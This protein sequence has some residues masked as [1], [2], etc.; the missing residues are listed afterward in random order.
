[1]AIIRVKDTGS[2]EIR[3]DPIQTQDAALATANNER[4]IKAMSTLRSYSDSLLDARQEAEDNEYV[5]TQSTEAELLYTQRYAELQTEARVNPEGASKRYMDFVNQDVEKRLST[6]RSPSVRRALDSQLSDKMARYGTR[7]I[8][9]ENNRKVELLQERTEAQIATREELAARAASLSDAVRIY[10]EGVG[11]INNMA[12]ILPKEALVVKRDQLKGKV[13]GTA[14]EAVIADNPDRALAQLQSGE[15]DQYLNPIQKQRA[16]AVAGSRITTINTINSRK[17]MDAAKV[18]LV[19]QEQFG[20]DGLRLVP[21]I[22]RVAGTDAANQ[23]IAELMIAKETNVLTN[24]AKSMSEE[25][26]A[27]TQAQMINEL[28][29]PGVENFEEKRRQLEMFNRVSSAVLEKRKE[30]PARAAREAIGVSGA[31]VEDVIAMQR[32]WGMGE[33][34]IGVLDDPKAIVKQITEADSIEAKITLLD[35]LRENTGDY[36]RYAVQD[37]V[38][39]GLDKEYVAFAYFDPIADAGNRLTAGRV[40]GS[41]LA[42]LRGKAGD[43]LTAE[44][45][46]AAVVDK[47]APF[48]AT[49]RHNNTAEAYRPLEIL[50]EK[51]A[52]DYVATGKSVK[53]AAETAAKVITDSFTFVDQNKAFFFAEDNL[54]P[55]RIPKKTLQGREINPD[56]ID[57]VRRRY[58]DLLKNSEIIMNNSDVPLDDVFRSVAVEQ[59][60]WVT[61]P[62]DSGIDFYYEGFPLKQKVG[63]KEDFITINFDEAL[64]IGVVNTEAMRGK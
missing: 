13:F 55:I 64:T 19:Q 60:Y 24:Q 57:A 34:Q 29:Q 17:V 56:T 25:N 12:E 33:G 18:A 21:E 61:R 7:A 5:A 50:I 35:G 2:R 30:S 38:R 20:V 40:I 3:V 51:M 63:D 49:V 37:L 44:S 43:S 59:G 4:R 58:M 62:D 14:I 42:D 48:M 47:L 27:I 9:W 6:A 16:I 36:Y 1:M 23:Y 15:W 28:R 26:I 54:P 41:S 11:F 31:S 53:D 10:D 8:T 22:E 32:E 45:T 52:L 46:R 39:N